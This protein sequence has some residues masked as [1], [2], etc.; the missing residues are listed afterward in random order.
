MEKILFNDNWQF[1]KF[2]IE[3]FS[4]AGKLIDSNGFEPVQIPHDWLIYDTSA[5]YEAGIGVY[6]KNFSVIEDDLNLRTHICFGGVYFNSTVYVN[7]K[8]VG[9]YRNGYIE[10]YWDITD[11]LT[12]GENE[13]AVVILHETPNTR[14]YSGAGIF[15]SVF[16]KKYSQLHICENGVY[17]SSN[18]SGEMKIDTSIENHG[19]NKNVIL[20]HSVFFGGELVCTS[21]GIEISADNINVAKCNLSVNNPMLWDIDNVNL[22][23]LKTEIIVENEVI[24]SKDTVF[25]FRKIEFNPDKGFLLNDR[26]VKLHGVC[27][28][29]DLGALGSAM[30]KNALK[31]QLSIM[32]EMGVNAI[33]T[34]HNMPSRELIDLCNEMGLLVDSEL[35]DMWEMPKTSNDFSRFFA[36]SPPLDVENW[37]TRDRNDPS[38]IMWSIG[39]EIYDTHASPKG[40]EIAVML[41]DLVLQYDYYNNA[42]VT[43]GSNFMQWQGAQNVADKLTLAGYNYAERLYN[44]HHEKYPHWFIYGSETSSAVRSRGIYR[45]PLEEVTLTSEDL[46]CSSYDNCVTGWGC[47]AQPSWI[48]DRDHDFNGGQFIWTGFDYIGEPTPY[49][50]K[51][52]YFGIVDTA[53]FPKDI[54]YFYQSVWTNYKTNPMIHLLPYWDW[55]LGEKINV[56]AY[57]NAPKAELFLDGKSLGIC[58]IDHLNGKKLYCQWDLNYVQGELTVKAYDED[59][60]VIANDRIASFKDSKEI[61]LKCDNTELYSNGTD[62]AFIEISTVDENVEFVANARNRVEVEVIGAAR[63]VG[64]DSGDSTDYDSYKGTSKRLFSGKLLAMVQSGFDSGEVKVKVTSRDLKSAEITLN[65]NKCDIPSGVSVIDKAV[66]SSDNEE[67]P[68]R[69]IEL[70][71]DGSTVLNKENNQITVKAKIYPEN[72]TYND[73]Y[74][75]AVG[76]SDIDTICAVIK[77]NNNTVEVVGASDGNFRL[78]AYVKNGE[79]FPQLYSEIQFSVEGLGNVVRNPYEFVSFS[80]YNY[81]NITPVIGAGGAITSINQYTYV[82]FDKAD[83]GKRGSDTLKL[84]IGN[85]TGS[86]VPVEIFSGQ[87]K[88]NNLIAV[89]NFPDNNGWDTYRPYEFKLD[90]KLIGINSL[91]F[92]VSKNCIFGGFEFIGENIAFAQNKAVDNDNIYGDSYSLEDG[93]IKNIGN[94][95]LI[96]FNDFDFSEIG[97]NK[98]TICGKTDNENNTI[99]LRYDE[100]GTQ[101]TQLLEFKKSSALEKQT[102]DIEKIYG[103]KDISFVFLPGSN[104]DFE[105]FIF[106]QE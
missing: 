101:K 31:R 16:L 15:R 67:I 58:E 26:K 1:K 12:A 44:E 20:K 49:S 21:D 47:L 88:D 105:S 13:I 73:I 43:I 63:L 97:A 102:F 71:H 2:P 41:R 34:S 33:R 84:Y 57:T 8:E 32:K 64:L 85:C 56:I 92:T 39:N 82:N 68:V 86:D 59:D 74:W 61:V 78:R 95:V 5:L 3:N 94:N 104:F 27:M 89:L 51:N 40:V 18:V 37:V 38:V 66:K 60:K 98:I 76:K 79:N 80:T 87:P 100:N 53:G 90:K 65:V 106:S 45:F 91:T 103:K 10:F 6:K 14:W 69:K 19:D 23:S 99:Q 7:K 96:S 9:T 25:G 75:R 11:F 46:Q 24:D 36:Q 22:Y 29:H 35:Y 81:C 83:F 72:A 30:N 55:N 50:T 17:V 54:Y 77:P 48:A 4:D 28:H 93:I 42:S 52:S 70:I 62:L